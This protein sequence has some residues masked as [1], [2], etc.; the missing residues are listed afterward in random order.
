MD[1]CVVGVKDGWKRIGKKLV[2]VEARMGT[3]GVIKSLS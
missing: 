1:M 3:Q 2:I